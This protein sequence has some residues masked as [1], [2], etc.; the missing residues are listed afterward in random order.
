MVAMWNSYHTECLPN[1]AAS[2]GGWAGAFSICLKSQMWFW[3]SWW[4]QMLRYMCIF[5]KHLQNPFFSPQ[6]KQKMFLILA[7]LQLTCNDKN[8]VRFGFASHQQH[9]FKCWFINLRY[10]D[11]FVLNWG[12]HFRRSL[13]VRKLWGYSCLRRKEQ[14]NKL[15]LLGISFPHIPVGGKVYS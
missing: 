9:G 8:C 4:C 14:S 12:L 13:D 3:T 1:E 6:W 7:S 10:I 5:L 2:V 15:C 11:L